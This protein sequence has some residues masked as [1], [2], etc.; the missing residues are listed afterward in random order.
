MSLKALLDETRQMP[1]MHTEYSEPDDEIIRY[2]QNLPAATSHSI[3]MR[4]V[5]VLEM[6]GGKPS[7]KLNKILDQ[8][9]E[10]GILYL[11]KTVQ[12][13]ARII[14]DP[15]HAA[16]R[17]E[18]GLVMVD[19]HPKS[20][21]TTLPLEWADIADGGSVSVSSVNTSRVTIDRDNTQLCA[22][23]VNIPRSRGSYGYGITDADVID[24][25]MYAIASGLP[26][27]IDSHV[28]EAINST[29]PTAFT[30]AK[31]ADK[32]IGFA[33]LRA[34]SGTSVSSNLVV[35]AAGVLRLH[36]IQAEL[37]DQMAGGLIGHWQKV[38][39]FIEPEL[40]L[41]MKR[42]DTNGAVK[43]VAM[44]NLQVLLPANS[45]DFFWSN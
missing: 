39:I 12:A 3:D 8:T 34:L 23:S 14:I 1:L 10:S 2:R 38:A 6:L 30:L 16:P 15:P 25:A 29:V 13:G 41:V 35:D 20:F 19:K 4:S 5:T 7:A 44:I 22:V 31:A 18:G 11:A 21:S 42:M 26:N 40:N 43:L 9:I 28:L 27:V 17:S 33:D 45:E 24:E 37:T 36:G 32:G